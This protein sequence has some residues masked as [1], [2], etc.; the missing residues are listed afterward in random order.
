MSMSVFRIIYENFEE[1]YE[2]YKSVMKKISYSILND[3]QHSEDAVQEA[4]TSLSKHE[5][6]LEK[7]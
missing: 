4:M 3:W 1:A 5:E 2:N 6:K 7:V